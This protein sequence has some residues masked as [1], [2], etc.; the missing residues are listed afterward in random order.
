[1]DG[2]GVLLFASLYAVL[3]A[4]SGSVYGAAIGLA[5]A[6]AGAV[7]LHGVALLRHGDSRGMK[8][9][10]ASQPFLLAAIFA[11]CAFRLTHFEM[12]PI[13]ETFRVLIEQTAQQLGLTVEEYAR[14]VNRWTYRC[15]AVA[16]LAY[17]GGMT[18]YYLRRRNAVA[19][20]LGEP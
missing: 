5:A 20:A 17:Q 18:L 16:S 9:L 11:Y 13:P 6:G 7:E 3:S 15:L 14:M 10:I 2:L 4:A 12:P 19:I 1:M 8:W